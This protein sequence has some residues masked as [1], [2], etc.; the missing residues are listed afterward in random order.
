MFNFTSDEARDF[1]NL[2]NAI[3]EMGHDPICRMDPELFFPD[4]PNGIVNAGSARLA[5]ALCQQCPVMKQCADYGIKY[6]EFGIF[7]GLSAKDRSRLRQ[8]IGRRVS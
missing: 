6:A 4:A 1:I 3:N 2:D 7:G 5:K 8:R